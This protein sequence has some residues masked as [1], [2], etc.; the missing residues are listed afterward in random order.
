M[1]QFL[2]GFAERDLGASSIDGANEFPGLFRI[3]MPL[4]KPAVAW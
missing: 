1:R 2:H 3:I 4:A